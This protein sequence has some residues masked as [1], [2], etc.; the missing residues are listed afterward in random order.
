MV[1]EAGTSIMTWDLAKMYLVGT[2]LRK[3]NG[4]SIL[5]RTS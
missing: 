2:L 3:S 4:V 1:L 5:I